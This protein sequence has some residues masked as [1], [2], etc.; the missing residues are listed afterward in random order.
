MLTSVTKGLSK[1]SFLQE[2]GSSTSFLLDTMAH[3]YLYYA[4]SYACIS[5]HTYYQLR[6]HLYL[7]PYLYLCP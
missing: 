4:C 6:L 1:H 7:Y 5:I 3:M 2:C